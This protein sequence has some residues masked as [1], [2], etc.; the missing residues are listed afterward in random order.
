MKTGLFVGRMDC[1]FGIFLSLRGKM[2]ILKSNFWDKIHI[3]LIIGFK[4]SLPS[5][6]FDKCYLNENVLPSNKV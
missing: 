4:R 2:A 6:I 5:E 1:C 3:D